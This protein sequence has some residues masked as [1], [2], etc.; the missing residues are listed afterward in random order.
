LSH[1]AEFN[2]RLDRLYEKRTGWLR[3]VLTKANPGPVPRLNKNQRERAIKHL[4][5]IAS[6]ALA[7]RMAKKEFER[8]VAER[9]TWKT[10]GWGT[11]KKLKLFRAW[12]RNR[13]DRKAGKVY[14][15]WHNRKCLYVGRTRGRGSRP[16]QH[17]KKEWFRDTTRIVVYMAPHKRDIPR[18]ECLAFHRFLPAKNKVKIAK[19]K[20]TPKCPLCRLHRRIK[21]EMRTLFRFR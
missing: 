2:R 18:L 12:A 6:D 20:W 19:E 10:T 11:A 16:S 7:R 8:S 3:T 21:T 13:I 15:F 17:F 14:V 1:Q 9:K 4:Q 5:G